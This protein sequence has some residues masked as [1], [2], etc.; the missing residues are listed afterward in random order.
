M[1]RYGNLNLEYLNN[2]HNITIWRKSELLN[3]QKVHLYIRNEI[4]N[5]VKF[6]G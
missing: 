5:D 4:K 6:N 2:A 1:L 3:E